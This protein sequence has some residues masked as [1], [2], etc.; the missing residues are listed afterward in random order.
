MSL[1][2]GKLVSS[3]SCRAAG[4]CF[5]RGGFS[6]QSGWGV[7]EWAGPYNWRWSC[8][9]SGMSFGGLKELWYRE[10]VIMSFN[11]RMCQSPLKSKVVSENTPL[12]SVA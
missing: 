10:I 9:V 11:E 6:V 5:S 8:L 12:K 3:E 4:G 2:R 7:D 1:A